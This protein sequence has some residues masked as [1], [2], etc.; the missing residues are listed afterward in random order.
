MKETSRNT[1]IDL[2]ENSVIKFR[3]NTFLFEK[4]KDKW[5]ETSYGETQ[6]LVY[7]FGAGLV[8]LGVKPK[9]N[10]A[11]LSEGRNSWVIGELAMFYAGAVNVPLSIKLEESNDLLFRLK[12]SESLYIMVSATQLPKIR[13]IKS[14][15]P[16]LKYIIVLDELDEYQ[17]REISMKEVC[18]K[19]DELLARDKEG[20]LKIGQSIENDD[21]ATITYTSGTTADPKGIMLTHR[22]YTAN[23]EQSLSL[24]HVEESWR[25]LII[26]PLDH[27]FAHVVGFYIFMHRGA[28][29][30]TVQTGR[31]AL[32]TLKNIPINLKEIQPDML[33]SVPALA[34]SF[35]KAIESGVKAK[36][37]NVE[38]LFNFALKVSYIY[39]KEGWNKGS[40]FT[41]MLKPLVKLFD[42]ILFSSIRKG[43]CEN[44]KFF[45]GGGALLDKDLQDFY[46][47]IGIPMFQGYGLSEATPVISSN[48][49]ETHKFGSSGILV[50]PLEL[51]I[52]DHDGNIIPQGEKGEI[53]IKGENVMAGYW[54][55]E[56]ATKETVKDNWLYT[57]DLGYMDKDGFLV[58]LGRY[59]SL[60]IGSDGE[61]YSPEGIEEALVSHSPYIE[62]IMLYNNQNAYTSALIVPNCDNLK[63]ACKNTW[64][65]DEAKQEAIRLVQ[66]TIN[67]FKGK[68]SQAGKFPE[69]WLPTTF[70]LLQEPFSEK[71]HMINSTMKMVRPKIEEHYKDLISFLNSPEGKNINNEQNMAA[72][73]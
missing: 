64:G 54:K 1:L 40:G 11:L 66:A 55:N 44:L 20:F 56:E 36:G 72:I 3:N 34:K 69:R 45:I 31:T 53:V 67:D 30:A 12:H 28:A 23:V 68:G 27:C 7:Q 39:N 58:V 38:K 19:G 62:Q 49:P 37:K 65:T 35:R 21:I 16:D 25:T 24:T 29:I 2:F 18:K 26:L 50:K 17:D 32:E 71:N 57:G 61:K 59:K 14:E 73:K 51:V 4:I 70:A 6:K 41:F 60:L 47:A 13:A 9:N 48:T 8:E 46:Y 22:N 33:L 52:K 5:T 63:R 42:K 10:I 43:F 15:L